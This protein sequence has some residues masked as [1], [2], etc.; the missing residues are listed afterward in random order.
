MKL[1]TFLI[2]VAISLPLSAARRRATAPPATVLSIEFVDVPA[3]GTTL[4]TAGSDAMVELNTVSQQAGSMGK[5][6]HVRRQFGIRIFRKGGLSWGTATVTARLDSPDGRSSVRID[7][8]LVAGLPVVVDSRAA[9][10]AMTI[11]TLEIEVRDSVA[12]GPLAASISWEATT[13]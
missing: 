9:V 5:S 12:P 11:H 3:P 8:K 1:L 10:G 4:I 6:V 7:G 13:Q 2:C